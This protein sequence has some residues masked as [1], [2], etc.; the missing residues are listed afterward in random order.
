M[1][2]AVHRSQEISLFGGYYPIEGVVRTV[3]ASKFADKVVTGDISKES[4]VIRSSWIIKDQ[5][6]GIGVKDMDEDLHLDRVWWST[7][8]LNTDGHLTLPVLTTDATNPSTNAPFR[9]GVEYNNQFFAVFGA[10]LYRR[11]EVD[12]AWS[13]SLGT[14]VGGAPTDAI[15]H[16]GKIYFACGTDFNRYD[17]TTLTNGAAL[18]SAQACRYFTEWHDNLYA[19]DNTGQLDFSVD[20]GVTWI[21]DAFSSKPSGYF[22]SMFNYHDGSSP[23]QIIIYVGTKE[24]LLSHDNGSTAFRETELRY[25]FNNFAG[26]SE[27]WRESSYIT[28]GMQVYQY[29]TS[30]Q[31]ASIFEMGLDQNDG[32]PEE[33]VGHITKLLAGHNAMY[34]FVDATSSVDTRDLFGAEGDGGLW[35]GVMAD[36]N[37]G[38]STIFR[39]GG[40]GSG[41][42][43]V[44][45]GPATGKPVLE[46]IIATADNE[47]RLWFGIEETVK[48]APLPT[49]LENPSEVSTSEFAA[50]SE[51]KTGWFDN[52]ES[53][54]TKLAA[55][56]TG[57]FT[58]MSEDE[59][60][61]IY[62]GTDYDD[63]DDNLTLLTNDDFPDGQIDAN[64][65]VSFVL[66]DGAGVAF[67]AIRFKEDLARG[68]TNTNSPD[69]RW[70][71]LSFV[72]L[73]DVKWGFSVRVDCTKNY[74]RRNKKGLVEGLKTALKTQT[75]GVFQFRD[76]NST[77]THRVRI[78]DMEA[79]EIGGKKHEGIFDL[80]LIAP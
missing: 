15:V 74:R 10:K 14:L 1:T 36:P 73:L 76:G 26:K 27:W 28:S 25:P 32:M 59:F 56:I 79:A 33:F 40:S 71:R 67:K 23:P 22:T 69:R 37:E 42:S 18:G 50:A 24:G 3:L 53:V 70:L 52:N 43:V 77:E 38:Y 11:T 55:E 46:G 30:G 2:T 75:M 12:G 44:Y 51:N 54:E 47:N 31:G 58:D 9:V 80:T 39:W 45:Q 7:S 13:S 29:R 20:E 48:Y 63:N 19:L 78:A 6:G 16:K 65:E 49:A 60:I 41:W 64:G 17:G 4:E 62:Y 35:D 21:T 34:A 72:P 57:F 8:H 61:K 68:S 5:R 66:A